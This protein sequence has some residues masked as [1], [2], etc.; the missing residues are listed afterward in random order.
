[1]SFLTGKP[2]PLRTLLQVCLANSSLC[3]NRRLIQPMAM[4]LPAI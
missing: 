3:C 1:M 2:L 4:F